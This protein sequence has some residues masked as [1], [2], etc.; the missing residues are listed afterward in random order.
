MFSEEE[1]INDHRG[2]ADSIKTGILILFALILSRLWYLQIYKGEQLYRYSL[3]NRLRKE[4]LTAPRGMIFSRDNEVLVHNI[5]R[6]DVVIV[7]QYLR[8]K[9][10]SIE[11][12]SKV[13]SLPVKEIKSILKKNRRQARYLPIVIK[14]NISRREVA[15]IET[16]NFKMPGIL[17]KIFNGRRYTDEK[18]GGHLL[19]YIS[20][21]SQAQLIRYGKKNRFK[22]RLGDFVGQ[23]GIE[24]KMDVVLRGRKGYEFMEVDASGKRSRRIKEDNNFFQRI[25]NKAARSGR[26]IRLTID[27]DMQKSAYKSLKGW[28]G[29]VVAV[30][31]KTGEILTMVSRPSFDPSHFSRGISKEYWSS[32]VNND[33]NP[34]RDR[35]IQEHYSPGSTFKLITAIA[36]M[37][38][39]I[40]DERTEVGCRGYFRA[41]RRNFHCW[42]WG[43]HGKVNLVQALRESCDVYFYKIATKLDIDVLARYARLFRLGSKT[44]IGL[45]REIPGLIPTKNWK[46][47]KTGQ[48]WHLGETLSCAIGQS[49]VLT[50]PLQLALTYASVANGGKVFRPQIIKEIFS[51]SGEIEKR[52]TPQIVSEIKLEPKTLK[53]IKKG[54]FEVVNERKG[55]AWGARGEGFFMSGK[56]GTSQVIRMSTDKLFSKCENNKYKYRHH[57]IF[58]GYAPTK[59]PEIAV[60]VVV[61]HGCQGSKVA[62]PIARDVM[63]T[64]MRKYHGVGKE[65]SDTAKGKPGPLKEKNV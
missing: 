9:D 45:P 14:K 25:E 33:K 12:L 62:A 32:I 18:I 10:Q 19:G 64:Y 17:V 60:S 22:Y 16:E 6:F 7:P 55:T 34:L 23:G 44:N 35:T 63:A 48:E 24:E 20:E 13:I 37:E 21:I 1:I 52:N 53:Y 15:V 29:S 8:H 5:P 50:T 54:L 46:K 2:R 3:E 40:I 38:E 65:K 43:G 61:E 56:T 36:A 42:R 39:G 26:N 4:I 30:N 51:N 28:V 58:V 47:K 11:K 27:W 49:Y 59:K 57:A 41:G 31:V